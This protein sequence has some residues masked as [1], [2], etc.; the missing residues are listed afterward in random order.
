[1]NRRLAH[2]L[3]LISLEPL[4]DR[5]ALSGDPVATEFEALVNNKGGG[6][7]GTIYSEFVNYY[8]A[9]SQGSFLS[10]QSNLAQI[11]G[12][13]VEID[14]RFGQG[15][16]VANGTQMQE[17]GMDITAGVPSIGLIEGFMPISQLPIVAADNYVSSLAPVLKPVQNP[18]PSANAVVPIGTPTTPSATGTPAPITNPMAEAVALKGGPVLGSIF[19]EFYNY[20]VGG[21]SGTFAPVQAGQVEIAGEAV[22]VDIRTSAA[23]YDAVLGAMEADGMLV[24]ATAPQVGVI[25]GFLPIAELP[26]VATNYAI[27][28]ISPVYKPIY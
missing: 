20:E 2:K 7:L 13:S 12:T 8:E 28:G 16:F 18:I 19:Q 21:A 14:V 10:A 11:A 6:L 1:M 25:E 9:G 3:T 22:G 17:L 4:E 24:T 15:N 5:L 26:T 27:S 23:N